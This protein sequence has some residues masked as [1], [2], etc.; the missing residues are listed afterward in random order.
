[1]LHTVTSDWDIWPPIHHLWPCLHASPQDICPIGR[2]DW[3]KYK[4]TVQPSAG[5]VFSKQWQSKE[6][7]PLS[8]TSTA[9]SQPIDHLSCSPGLS[10]H[11]LGHH[12]PTKPLKLF[13]LVHFLFAVCV[14]VCVPVLCVAIKVWLVSLS[15]IGH[16]HPLQGRLDS[17]I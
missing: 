13:H 5:S 17:Y 15:P 8:G 9:G 4:S 14:C 3:N 16:F 2:W 7:K 10:Q 6:H 1:M 12:W 11:T